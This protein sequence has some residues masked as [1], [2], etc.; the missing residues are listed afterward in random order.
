M[1]EVVQ[2]A[3]TGRVLAVRER[4][5]QEGG[6]GGG[7]GF[8]DG[9]GGMALLTAILAEHC[10]VIE[11][12]LSTCSEVVLVAVLCSDLQTVLQQPLLPAVLICGVGQALLNHPHPV[13]NFCQM[14]RHHTP[15]GGFSQPL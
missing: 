8:Q 14:P 6:G 1:R 2:G 5:G 11:L 15:A 7:G 9:D 13:Y 10:A 12:T 4:G 3:R